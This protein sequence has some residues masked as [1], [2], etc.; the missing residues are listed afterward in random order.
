MIENTL[1]LESGAALVCTEASLSVRPPPGKSKPKLNIPLKRVLWAYANGTSVEVHAAVDKRGAV[2]IEGKVPDAKQADAQEWV[3]GLMEAAYDGVKP[4]RRFL[5]IVNPIGGPGKAASIFKKIVEPILRAARCSCDTIFTEYYLHAKKVGAELDIDAFD[6]I[7]SVSGDGIVHE[8]YNGMA[9]HKY[10]RKAFRMP[11]A[12]IPAGSGNGLSLNLLGLKDGQNIVAATVNAIKGR[13]M[14]VD[15]CSVVQGGK[16]S[17]SYM[18]QCLGLMADLDL[19]TEHLRILG[20]N[21]FVYG[22]VR[23]IVTHKTYPFSISIRE[24]DSDKHKMA[25]DLREQL[26]KS[27]DELFLSDLGPEV[28]DSSLPALLYADEDDSEWTKIEEAVSYFYGGKCAYV[29]R[30]LMQFPVCMPNDGAV[31]LAIQRKLPRG[32]M[33]TAM[34]SAE[35]GRLY[36]RESNLYYKAV[37]YRLK[38]LNKQGYLS[39][40]GEKFPFKEFHVEVH[41]GLGT[42]LSCYG[43][44]RTE[45][46]EALTAPKS[47][48]K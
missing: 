44:Y 45:R 8:L 34:D 47:K 14:P 46:N 26:T 32:E 22:Y 24:K 9:E 36:W 16:R 31:D 2:K 10:P 11:I 1:Q 18:S 28:E 23:G 38:P 7:L 4:Q 30:D 43:H 29:S 6:A 35:H 41:Q 17:F 39:I 37:A 12:P 33:V 19:G 40:D 20:S 5:A 25:N 27:P 21:R 13:P 42:M 48:S 15:V 3:A